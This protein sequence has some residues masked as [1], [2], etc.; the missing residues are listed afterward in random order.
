[1]ADAVRQI[2]GT[3]VREFSSLNLNSINGNEN[4]KFNDSATTKTKGKVDSYEVVSQEVIDMGA[5]KILEM[6]I[7]AKICIQDK[8]AMRDILLIGDFTYKDKSWPQFRNAIKSVFS[9][10]SNSFELNSGNPNSAYH[11]ISITGRIDQI[12]QDKKVDRQAMEDAQGAAIFNGI[13][14]S[15][16]QDKNR[17]NPF[18]GILNSISD[19]A[20]TLSRVNV[21]VYVSVSA[22]HKTDNRSY[23]ASA[24]AEK[25]VSKDSVTSIVDALT[26]EA[27]KKASKDLYIKLNTNSNEVNIMDLLA[28]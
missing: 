6:V 9:Q 7:D 15:M 28:Y 23:T 12:S 14:N 10:Q 11:D 21:K 2:S 3:E 27:T 16:N 20:D 22:N 17:N 19:N 24:A 4:E 25:E 18:S 26:F 1:L 13:F 5:G 8:S